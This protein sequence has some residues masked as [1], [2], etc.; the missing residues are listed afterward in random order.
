MNALMNA[1]MNT[2]LNPDC[3]RLAARTARRRLVRPSWRAIGLSVAISI[4]AHLSAL[5]ALV[6]GDSVQIA[7]G[8]PATLAGLGNS[9]ADFTQGST[10]AQPATA[11]PSPVDPPRSPEA[12]R[13]STLPVQPRPA[14]PPPQPETLAMVSPE[15]PGLTAPEAAAPVVPLAL[16]PEAPQP[17]A[18]APSLSTLPP[19]APVAQ[20]VIEPS[21]TE[22][23]SIATAMPRTQAAQAVPATAPETI[24]P[25]PEVTVQ[26]ADVATPRP[27]RRPEP[28]T[29][30]RQEPAQRQ[31]A[32]TAPASA[33][34]AA[35]NAEHDARRG[36]AEGAASASATATGTSGAVAQP[37]NAT[38]SNY[39]GQVMDRIRRTRQQRVPGRGV[40]VVSFSIAGNGGL[41]AASIQR[42]SGSAAIDAAAIDHIRRAAPFPA[43]PAGAGRSFSFEFVVR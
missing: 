18:V 19:A 9:F 30:A 17:E 22:P 36:S 39:P 26:Q 1:P 42:S 37:G 43:P 24:A 23:S 7:G 27:Q 20:R 4:V 11:E 8:A 5:A 13:E 3:V 31:R 15:A 14:A 16:D 32:Q 40:A 2:C 33:P 29:Q 12:T 34:Q 28:R 21:R 6:P 35:G 25:A 38:V 10:P 41:S